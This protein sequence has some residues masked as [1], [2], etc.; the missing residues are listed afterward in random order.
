MLIG[1][2]A[3]SLL[4]A[5][6][7]SLPALAAGREGQLTFLD[8]GAGGEAILLHMPSGVTA[9]LDGGPSGPALETALGGRLPFWRHTLDLVALTDARAGNARGLED[10]ASHFTIAHAIDAGA[11]HP[12]SEYLAYLDAMRRAGAGHQTF[13]ADD[14][15]HLSGSTTL[16]A[17]GPPQSLYPPNEGDTTASDDLILRLETP[18]LRALLLGAADAYALDALAGSGEPLA[19]DVVVVAAPRGAPLDLN[20]PLR[21]VLRLAQPRAII[22]CDAPT[23]ASHQAGVVPTANMWTSDA[24]VTAATGAQVYRLSDTGALSLSGDASGWTLG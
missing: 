3:A 15:L 2:L 1:A 16:T 22:V 17:L 19:A 14:T 10:A 6:G 13:R 24:D 23:T 21:D 12:T 18:G 5:C 7:A 11:L 9:L 4:G 20:G 8:V